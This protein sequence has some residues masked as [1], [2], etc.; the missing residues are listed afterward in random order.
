MSA[1]AAA[2]APNDPSVRTGAFGPHA[3]TPLGALAS[4]AYGAVLGPAVIGVA[5]LIAAG[6]L[7]L[8]TVPGALDMERAFTAAADCPAAGISTECRHTVGAPVTSVAADHKHRS[9]DYWLGLGRPARP[10]RPE[11]PDVVPPRVKMDGRVPV[12]AAVHPGSALQLTYWRGQIRYVDYHGLRQY[13]AADPRGGY[14]LPFAA[15]LVLLSVGGACLR[16]AYRRARRH[17]GEPPAHEPW[18]L[19]VPLASVLLICCFAFATPW[20]TSGVPTALLLAAVGAVPVLAGAAWLT[21]RRHHRTT[22]TIRVAPLSPLADECFPG[23]VLGEVPY[24]H[25][26]FGYLVAGPGLLAAT[27]D[28]SGRIA[29]RPVPR[30]LVAVRV[31]P[32][33]WTD[34]GPRPAPGAHVVECRDGPTPVYVVTHHAYVPRVLGALRCPTQARLRPSP[35]G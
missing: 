4:T 33:Y 34:P 9:T 11:R 1:A 27:P 10:Q 17:A 19:T 21:R 6:W 26:G 29:R 28:P 3:R 24:S 5:F 32:P 13:T 22:D 16:T 30:T 12:F 20:V 2:A 25:E 31:R 18:R 8:A 35:P 7:L 14:R 15:A 23:R